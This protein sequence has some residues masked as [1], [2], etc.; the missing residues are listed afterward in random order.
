MEYQ[1]EL[2]NGGLVRFNT[3]QVQAFHPFDDGAN[4]RI[5]LK[6]GRAFILMG[7]DWLEKLRHSFNYG[8]QELDYRQSY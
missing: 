5:V 6:N 8:V 7:A 3:N 4:T 1:A 2:K